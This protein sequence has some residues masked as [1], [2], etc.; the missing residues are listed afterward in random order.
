M[1]YAREFMD[2]R[3]RCV[4]DVENLLD[5]PVLVTLPSGKTSSSADN[6]R[7]RFPLLGK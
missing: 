2:R 5:I 4:D 1:A 6:K 7:L 3:V